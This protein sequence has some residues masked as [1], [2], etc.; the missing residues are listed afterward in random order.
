MR[1]IVVLLFNVQSKF[2][3]FELFV[4]HRENDHNVVSVCLHD[5]NDVNNV[6]ESV[7]ANNNVLSG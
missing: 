7:T 5:L 4:K 1:L 6:L 2:E 3:Y